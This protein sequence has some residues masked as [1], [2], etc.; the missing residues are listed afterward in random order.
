MAQSA[1][2]AEGVPALAQ[3]RGHSPLLVV[4]QCGQGLGE[5][6]AAGQAGFLQDPA[7]Q[8]EPG[9]IP[10]RGGG[11]GQNMVTLDPGLLSRPGWPGQAQTPKC[12]GPQVPHQQ[13]QCCGRDCSRSA[14]RGVWI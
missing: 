7:L 3:R 14:H 2:L 12:W 5:S 13:F 11:G 4:G 6:A 1:P 10:D 8:M 9:W